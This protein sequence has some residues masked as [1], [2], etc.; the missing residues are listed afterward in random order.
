MST[1]EK[2][3]HFSDVLKRFENCHKNLV[4]II[5]SNNPFSDLLRN[6]SSEIIEITLLYRQFD[7]LRN[8]VKNPETIQNHFEKYLENSENVVLKIRESAD[9]LA[10]TGLKFGSI[11][12]SKLPEFG[13]IIKKQFFKFKNWIQSRVD[14]LSELKEMIKNDMAYIEREIQREFSKI[15]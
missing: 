4:S 11:E 12:E 7:K 1:L 14:Y 13:E 6:N 5:N 9:S 10:E 2:N 3:Q 15:K 8:G